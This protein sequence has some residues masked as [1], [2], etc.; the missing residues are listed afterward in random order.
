VIERVATPN[1]FSSHPTSTEK[2]KALNCLI[3]IM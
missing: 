3:S 2:T 1:A